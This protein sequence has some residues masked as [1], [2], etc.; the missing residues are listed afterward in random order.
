MRTNI[1]KVG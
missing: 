1:E